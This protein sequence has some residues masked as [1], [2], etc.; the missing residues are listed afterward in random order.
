MVTFLP[1]RSAIYDPYPPIEWY[2]RRVP[3]DSND[4]DTA[5]QQ[6]VRD[7]TTPPD[8][9]VLLTV[10]GYVPQERPEFPPPS[11]PWTRTE[12]NR[13]RAAFLAT[14]PARPRPVASPTHV[15]ARETSEGIVLQPIPRISGEVTLI[16]L[17]EPARDSQDSVRPPFETPPQQQQPAPPQQRELLQRPALS[18]LTPL[19]QRQLLQAVTGLR[20]WHKVVILVAVV[21]MT[22]LGVGFGLWFGHLKK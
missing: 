2:E 20:D 17:G 6:A 22:I 14:L 12:V 4:L 9:P 21:S 3:I 15:V 16:R 7:G 10:M 5:S 13:A 11:E 1:F 18:A 8:S 19:Q